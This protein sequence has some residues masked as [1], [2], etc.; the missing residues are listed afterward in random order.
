MRPTSRR[1]ASSDSQLQH[2]VPTGPHVKPVFH[3]GFK[4]RRLNAAAAGIGVS[5]TR[6]VERSRHTGQVVAPLALWKKGVGVETR[7]QRWAVGRL[8][9]PVAV[10]VNDAAR[11]GS[12]TA[13]AVTRYP[14]LRSEVSSMRQTAR[15]S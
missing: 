10:S 12:L 7:T 3:V 14:L 11:V 2:V 5:S 8:E 6:W 13:Q 1:C 4:T 15:R 9:V